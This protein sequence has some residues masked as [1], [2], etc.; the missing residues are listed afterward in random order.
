MIRFFCDFDG[1]VCFDD[2]GASFFKTFLKEKSNEIT[3]ALVAGE[4]SLRDW[5]SRSVDALPLISKDEFLKFID[6][7][8]VDA[9]FIEFAEYTRNNGIDI[10]ILSDGLDIYIYSILSNY[11]L[12]YLKVFA[13]HVEFVPID[14]RQKM[15]VQFPYADAECKRCGNCKRNHL[16]TLSA[17]EDIIVYVGDGYSDFC[18]AEYADYI[19]AK[20]DL[21]KYCQKK[22]ITYFEFQTFKDVRK[23]M[24]ELLSKKRIKQRQQ[25]IVARK[26]VFMQG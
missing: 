20:R 15:I 12:E 5:L 22:N 25:A 17:D 18:P 16:L 19:F 13:N 11:N 9:D 6:Q 8:K 14:G 24:V 7:F 21:L 2:V 10:I 3:N 26:D 4:I 1:T 23:K